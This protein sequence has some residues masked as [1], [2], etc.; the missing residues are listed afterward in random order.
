MWICLNNAF[1]SIVEDNDCDQTTI[2]VRA[3]RKGDI[4]KIFPEGA[5]LVEKTYSRDYL[6]RAYL[7]RDYVA[8]VIAETVLN[9]SYPNF[10]SSVTDKKLANAYGSFWHTHADL[11]ASPP[12]SYDP[13][14]GRKGWLL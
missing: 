7:N 3:R 9:I 5:D 1:F 8:D 12:Y 4:E 10:K 6:Y 14:L 2:L 13:K 11:Q